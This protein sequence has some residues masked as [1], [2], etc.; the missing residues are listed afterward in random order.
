MKLKAW[1]LYFTILL[2]I[3]LPGQEVVTAL[4]H[5]IS[6]GTP[7][8][9]YVQ[10][11][12]FST[13]TSAVTSI[14]G[15]FPVNPTTGNVVCIALAV[16]TASIG[17]LTVKDGAGTPNSYTLS[18]SSPLAAT[19]PLTGYY[20]AIACIMAAPSSANKTITASWTG[21]T[22]N[23]TTIWGDE[24]HLSSGTAVVDNDA[25]QPLGTA[26]G[27]AINTTPTLTP[28]VA[29][30]LFYGVVIVGNSIVAPT[31]GGT[32]GV[33]TGSPAGN[34][35]TYTTLPEY[36]L[37]VSAATPVNYTDSGSGDVYAGLMIGIKP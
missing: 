15:T 2:S 36:D 13:T 1:V 16:S 33:W 18:P 10:S 21:S 28:A 11:M 27:T 6:A 5:P 17:T 30:E 3:P 8:F 20:L 35:S 32:L 14:T 34:D 24:F 12:P 9:T 4:R 31:A 23:G 26:I 37:S 25:T 22:S 29:G 7:T 19:A